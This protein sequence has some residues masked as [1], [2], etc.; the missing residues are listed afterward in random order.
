M[1]E[2]KDVKLRE[3]EEY[4]LELICKWRNDWDIL[5]T[6]FSYLPISLTKQRK[7]YENYL[8]DNSVQTFLIQYKDESKPIGTVTLGHI[9]YKNQ[10]AEIGVMIGESGYRGR[11]LAKQ[12]LK[13]LIEYGFK[14]LN[15]N[16]LYLQ[17]FEQNETAHQL[18]KSLGFKQEGVLRNH[19]FKNGT[20]C[21]VL[22][23]GL[24]REENNE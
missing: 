21:N 4:D 3:I 10:N 9:D 20:F 13:L 24:L 5:K 22:M 11:G 18:Y 6:V 14:E 12:T 8:N 7:W 17:L 16:R 15:L 19:Q 2:S 1:L 23:M